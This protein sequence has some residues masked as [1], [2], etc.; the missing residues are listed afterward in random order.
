MANPDMANGFRPWADPYSG[1]GQ[2]Q[3][4]E[5]DLLATNAV[6]GIGSPVVVAAGGVDHATAGT[7]NALLGIAAEAKAV[8]S[9]A[10]EKIKVWSDP[11]QLFVG[12]TDNGT[13]T[14]TALA[15]VGL[16]INFIGV[17]VGANN[18]S[19]SELDESSAAAGATIQF[20]I[21]RL[22]Q[23]INGKALNAFGE[24]NRFV[25]KINNHQKQGGTGTAG[26]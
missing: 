18:L 16:N 12:Q 5:H 8:N 15:A 2:P 24:F 19:T 9:G 13:G 26:V 23:E 22:A 1:G 3:I 6:V 4:T 14:A 20:K 7:G 10:G 17:A 25:V 21:M 11:Q